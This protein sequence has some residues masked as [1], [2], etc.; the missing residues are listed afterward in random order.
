M[1]NSATSIIRPPLAERV[2]PRFLLAFSSALMPELVGGDFDG[3][4]TGETLVWVTAG[5]SRLADLGFVGRAFRRGSLLLL[6]DAGG[7][8]GAPLSLRARGGTPPLV[9]SGDFNADGNLDLVIGGRRVSGARRGL[10]L[11][12]GNGDGTFAGP[13]PIA[14]APSTVTSLL[15]ADVNGDGRTDLVGTGRGNTGRGGSG[16]GFGAG[17]G[18]GLISAPRVIDGDSG[19]DDG[20]N[21]IVL[22]A[23]DGSNR[24]HLVGATAEA[25]GGR[26]GGFETFFFDGGLIGGADGDDPIFVL[27]NNGDGTF[28]ANAE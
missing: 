28:A 3:D 24:P 21:A 26:V 6:D 11:L 13:V 27:L 19:D 25:G 15:A 17:A 7:L 14:G 20:M 8:V 23:D 18:H 1:A 4:G 5:R 9:A 16:S 2:E 22:P 12:A 10:V